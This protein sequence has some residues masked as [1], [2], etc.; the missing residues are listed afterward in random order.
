MLMKGPS[1]TLA[2]GIGF[3]SAKAML[4]IEEGAGKTSPALNKFLD[5][6]VSK[7][8]KPKVSKDPNPHAKAPKFK[9]NGMWKGKDGVVIHIT[10]MPTS[11]VANCIAMLRMQGKITTAEYKERCLDKWGDELPS[12]ELLIPSSMLEDLEALLLYRYNIGDT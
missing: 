12:A 3:A 1:L 5:K 2:N 6:H 10:D 7:S 8:M 9:T 4:E 11:R